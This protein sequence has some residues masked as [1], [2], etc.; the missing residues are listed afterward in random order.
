MKSSVQDGES[1]RDHLSE[2]QARIG[3]PVSTQIEGW[4]P[5]ASAPMDG[6]LIRVRDG[7][8]QPCH[9]RFVSGEPGVWKFIEYTSF[10]P[11]LWQPIQS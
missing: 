8:W 5:I 11:T 6:T 4:M 3:N 2:N 7:R 9:A 1:A 10:S